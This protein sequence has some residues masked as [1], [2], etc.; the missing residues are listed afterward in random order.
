MKK[1]RLIALL[2]VIC[3]SV[4]AFSATAS[5][6]EAPRLKSADAYLVVDM[7]TGTEVAY[8]EPDTQHSIASLTKI[9]TCLLAVEAVE[10][11]E[12][13]LEDMVTAQ[14]DC[15]QG[16]DVSS[17]NAGITPGETMS[18]EDLLY[19]A[20][21]HSAN[22]ACNVIA[23]HVAG[24]ISGFVSLMNSRAAALGCENT[25]FMDTDGMYNR[26]DGHYSTPR[27]L[28]KITSEAL[29]HTLFARICGTSDYTVA[30]TNKREAF[31]IH[32]SNA[33][34]S[35]GGI[36]GDSYVYSGVY[37]VKTGFTKPAGYCLVSVCSRNDEN[38][39]CIVMGCNGPL[40][41]TFAGE[42]QNFQDSITLYN[43]AFA[44]FTSR[45][46]FLK[47]EPLKRF[48]VRN[49]KDDATVALCPAE[50][51]KLFMSNEVA[52]SDIIV[53]VHTYDE[54]MQAP[55]EAGDEIGYID[56]YI[57]GQKTKTVPAVA[58][59]SVEVERSLVIKQKIHDFFTS[60]GFKLTVIGIAA[61]V[62]GYFVLK[63][64]RKARRRRK[65]RARITEREQAKW[66]E[67]RMA[68][69][70]REDDRRRNSNQGSR[71]QQRHSA[72]ANSAYGNRSE[73]GMSGYASGSSSSYR[74]NRYS[75]G[76]DMPRQ[77][78]ERRQNAYTQQSAA[79]RR[80]ERPASAGSR[81]PIERIEVSRTTNGS[82]GRMHVDD[83]EY[84]LDDVLNNFNK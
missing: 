33:L 27:D 39:M 67:E 7:K 22:D 46:V 41:Y 4:P 8:L 38:L 59:A 19:C 54:L 75:E 21:V 6:V 57:K 25:H 71:T 50:S 31:E 79:V 26:S 48:S 64:S 13:G 14:E 3:L 80:G 76:Q 29:S 23:V 63:G 55:I 49:A 1:I 5:A 44:N 73:R 82:G 40:T 61:C 62:I 77:S 69:A 12:V 68:Y 17:S 53:D 20:L 36:Y 47:D 65:L 10:R 15:L 83:D 51:L 60:L 66:T 16:L 78:P 37:G 9:M 34:M 42:Y 2:L 84:R 32:N 81:I 70:A 11:G 52:D 74:Q 43:W 18:F 30:A 24:S 28:Y 45:T 56:V 72:A 35:T 58:D